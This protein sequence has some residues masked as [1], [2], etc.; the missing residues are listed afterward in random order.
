MDIS[1]IKIVDIDHFSRPWGCNI[2]YLIRYYFELS[3]KNGE[4]QEFRKY[5][6]HGTTT[7]NKYQ[8]LS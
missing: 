5:A 7:K 3:V 4:E 8:K 6:S 2:V 1:H